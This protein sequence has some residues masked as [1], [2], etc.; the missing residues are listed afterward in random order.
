MNTAGRKPDLHP[1]D[2]RMM[3]VKEA[4]KKY[5]TTANALRVSMSKNHLTLD[6]SVKRLE[7]RMAKKAEKEIMDILGF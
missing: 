4:A 6:G 1:V 5:H 7:A 3:T 2:G